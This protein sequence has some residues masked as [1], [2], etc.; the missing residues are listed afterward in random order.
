MQNNIIHRFCGSCVV[1]PNVIKFSSKL[2]A[3]CFSTQRTPCPPKLLHDARRLMP[4]GSDPNR[5]CREEF[6]PLAVSR[7]RRAGM[8]PSTPTPARPRATSTS[9]RRPTMATAGCTRKGCEASHGAVQPGR[10]RAANVFSFAAPAQAHRR[11]LVD[12]VTLLIGATPMLRLHRV[13]GSIA[14]FTRQHASRQAGNAKSGRLSALHCA[15]GRT[16]CDSEFTEPGRS[17]IRCAT[18]SPDLCRSQVK[19]R[20]ALSMTS[21][22]QRR[23]ELRVWEQQQS[24]ASVAAAAET[25]GNDSRTT[26][27]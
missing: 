4:R 18:Q 7:P 1:G 17:L 9:P 26:E 27:R 14:S 3:D 2:S 13:V 16:P 10:G 11:T 21:R 6:E 15:P 20:I 24:G 23:S 12:S 8:A 5:C 19:D 22:R 25:R